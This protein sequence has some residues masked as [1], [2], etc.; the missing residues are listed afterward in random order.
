[1]VVQIPQQESSSGRDYSSAVATRT[2]YALQHGICYRIHTNDAR[3]SPYHELVT[4]RAIPVWAN[5][6]LVGY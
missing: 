4:I 2:T 1:M 3:N 5:V 6:L